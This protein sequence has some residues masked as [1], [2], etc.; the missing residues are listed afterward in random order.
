MGCS[1]FRGCCFDVLLRLSSVFPFFECKLFDYT[2]QV[3]QHEW[4]WCYFMQMY[5]RTVVLMGTWGTFVTWKGTFSSCS[6]APFCSMS[7]KVLERHW[8]LGQCGSGAVLACNCML[9][10]EHHFLCAKAAVMTAKWACSMQWL[11]LH[12]RGAGGHKEVEYFHGKKWDLFKEVFPLCLPSPP[13]FHYTW[14]K[15]SFYFNTN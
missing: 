14:M 1:N 15:G 10:L 9:T 7:L 8:H 13:Y 2:A 5:V 4:K 6:E 12:D 3:W 11:L